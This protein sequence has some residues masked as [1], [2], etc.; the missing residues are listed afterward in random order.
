MQNTT[1]LC[2]W[3]HVKGTEFALKCKLY[4]LEVSKL[5]HW[6]TGPIWCGTSSIRFRVYWPK[7][8]SGYILILTLSSFSSNTTRSWSLQSRTWCPSIKK[9]SVLKVVL[10][11][12]QLG[13]ILSHKNLWHLTN[14]IQ[15]CWLIAIGP[16]QLNQFQSPKKVVMQKVEEISTRTELTNLK[17]PSMNLLNAMRF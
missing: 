17:E 1:C 6:L 5:F 11:Q 9:E 3:I 13:D 10:W 2:L 7:F 15:E 14:N 4:K 12:V 16:C 8:L